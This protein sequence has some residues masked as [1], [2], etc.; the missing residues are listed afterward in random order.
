M[1]RR[2]P[3]FT[4]RK[5]LDLHQFARQ[6]DVDRIAEGLRKANLPEGSRTSTVVAN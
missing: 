6:S 4:I 1:L 3:G 5:W 2:D